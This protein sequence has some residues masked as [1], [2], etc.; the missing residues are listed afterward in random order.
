VAIADL[1]TA[2]GAL[3]FVRV[4]SGAYYELVGPPTASGI[5]QTV[6]RLCAD[7]NVAIVD[8]AIDRVAALAGGLDAIVVACGASAAQTLQEAVDDVGSL[9]ARLRIARYDPS[10]DWIGVE[11]ALTPAM[12]AALLARG[13]HRQVVVRDPTQIALTGKTAARAFAAL[14]IRCERPLLVVAATV[15][16]IGRERG[17]EPRAFL[18]AVAAAT[19]LPTFDVY[20][21]ARAA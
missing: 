21:G 18:G 19:G 1:H 12:A 7:A 13:E 2:A 20:A 11:G 16:S 10:R 5:R 8:G 17:F 9:V 3:V 4:K 14:D 15:A 6:D